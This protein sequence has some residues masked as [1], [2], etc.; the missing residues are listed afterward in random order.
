[1]MG[2]QES[3]VT[4]DRRGLRDQKGLLVPR[5]LVDLTDSMEETAIP[6]TQAHQELL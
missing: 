3:L 1:M 6:E 4:R 2:L 5:V